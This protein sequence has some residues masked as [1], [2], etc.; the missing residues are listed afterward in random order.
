VF[1]NCLKVAVVVGNFLKGLAAAIS[2]K[3]AVNL[4]LI[5][6]VE[7]PLICLTD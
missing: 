7:E 4:S 3:A 6:V 2:I 5:E 1:Y